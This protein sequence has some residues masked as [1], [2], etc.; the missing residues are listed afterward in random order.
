[1]RCSLKYI[2]IALIAGAVGYYLPHQRQDIEL[3][4]A[5][6]VY[7]EVAHIPPS[8]YSNGTLIYTDA[9][10]DISYYIA[11]DV[12]RNVHSGDV[13]FMEDGTAL[14]VLDTTLKGFYL[15]IAGKTIQA[16]SSGSSIWSNNHVI[17]YISTMSSKDMLYCIW[18]T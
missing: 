13:V 3:Q 2:S 8:T 11:N 18:S 5:V 6:E 10:S 1:M 4:P 17:G 9:N 14:S 7:K 16:G 15:D 12:L